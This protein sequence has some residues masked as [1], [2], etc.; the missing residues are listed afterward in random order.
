MLLKL[1]FDLGDMLV[2]EEHLSSKH[3]SRV[4][5]ILLQINP[6]STSIGEVYRFIFANKPCPELQRKRLIHKGLC[7][8]LFPGR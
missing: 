6:G 7:L 5:G 1:A 2:F 8:F 3:Y 4:T